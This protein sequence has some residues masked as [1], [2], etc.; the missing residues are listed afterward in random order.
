MESKKGG[1]AKKLQIII[2][3]KHGK[4]ARLIVINV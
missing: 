2:S 4:F 3:E 1:E